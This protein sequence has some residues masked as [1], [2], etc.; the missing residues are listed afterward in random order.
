MHGERKSIMIKIFETGDLHLGLKYQDRTKHP[1]GAELAE[2]RYTALA[3]MVRKAN[4]EGCD[5]FVVTGDLFDNQDLKRI[6]AKAVARTADILA[7]FS[8]EAVLVL[9]GNHDW[10]STDPQQKNALWDRFR[11]RCGN[12]NVVLLSEF[13][14]YH[15]EI[16]EESVV[17]YPAFCQSKTAEENNL[18]WIKACEMPQDGSYRIG[19]AHGAVQGKTIDSE[20]VYFLMSEDELNEIPVDVWL[21]G[22]THVMFPDNLNNEFQAAGKIYNAGTHVQDNVKRHTEG[23]C[24]ILEL[25]KNGTE[26]TAVRAKRFMSGNTF[27]KRIEI[28]VVPEGRTGSGHELKQAILKATD[29]LDKPKTSLSL[30]ISGI[31]TQEEIDEREAVYRECLKGFLECPR[32]KDDKLV[33]LVTEDMIDRQ[34]TPQ[35]FPSRLLKELLDRPGELQLAA[36]LMDELK[37]AK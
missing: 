24:V 26:P 5:L 11:D 35:S 12:S 2:R 21:L 20:G 32:P 3:D 36:D 15:F 14:P 17:V 1:N 27:F 9:P 4:E 16:G 8:G 23:Y 22:H 29:S 37:G 18:G 30:I 7:G 28:Q 34:Y 13:E 19:V 31:A 25:E 10:Y 33:K 6:P